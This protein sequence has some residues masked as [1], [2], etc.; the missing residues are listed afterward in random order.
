MSTAA[1]VFTAAARLGSLT[2][3]AAMVVLAAA[4][5]GLADGEPP[6][7]PAAEVADSTLR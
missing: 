7:G 2:T 4:L 6:T 1:R 3:L 5:A